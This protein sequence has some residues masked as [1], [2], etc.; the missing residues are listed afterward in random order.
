[1]NKKNKKNTIMI[2]LLVLLTLI[3][4]AEILVWIWGA[5]QRSDEEDREE[6]ES[7]EVDSSIEEES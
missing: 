3:L 2:V 1:M 4:L 6:V 7:S 5:R